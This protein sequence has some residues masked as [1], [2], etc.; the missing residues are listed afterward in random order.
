MPPPP[1]RWPPA[2]PLTEAF[3]AIG[4]DA[5]VIASLIINVPAILSLLLLYVLLHMA[6]T[7]MYYPGA[8]RSRAKLKIPNGR[9]ICAG[10]IQS[11]RLSDDDFVELAGVDAMAF[12]EFMRLLLRITFSFMLWALVAE[13][14][15]YAITVDRRIQD[16]GDVPPGFI[17][18]TS[19]ANVASIPLGGTWQPMQALS[20]LLSLVGIWLNTIYAL[21][22]MSRTWRKILHWCHTAPKE[23]EAVVAYSLLVRARNPLAKPIRQADALQAWEDLYPGEIHSVRMVR[24]TGNLPRLLG[25]MDRL[26]EQL[27]LLQHQRRQIVRHGG[28]PRRRTLF[29]LRPSN[30]ERS[31]AVSAKLGDNSRAKSA[32]SRRRTAST[33]AWRLLGVGAMED[34]RRRGIITTAS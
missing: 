7:N 2:N 1:P 30:A 18:R 5:E 34:A 11:W 16:G 31:R 3:G 33:P 25:Q 17:A 20:L 13:T 26:E 6:F 23:D 27:Q 8:A 12:I 10:F 21:V 4:D 29:G 14:V 24:H 32:R 9:G 19:L 28:S 22:H 15:V